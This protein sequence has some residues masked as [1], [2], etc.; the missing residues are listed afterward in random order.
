MAKTRSL[1][2]LT[3]FACLLYARPLSGTGAWFFHDFSIAY[4]PLRV[5][6]A[7]AVRAGHLPLWESRMGNGF[8]VLA[9]SQAGVFY[10]PHLLGYLGLPHYW[11]YAL[12]IAAHGILA[13]FL[14][15]ALCGLFGLRTGPCVLAGL[16]YGFSGYYVT[17]AMHIPYVEAPA[18]TPGVLYAFERWLREPRRVSWLGWAALALGVQLVVCSAQF[19]LYSVLALLLYA[20]IALIVRR[21]DGAS[22]PCR[23]A[24]GWVVL[25]VAAVIPVA[26]AL[27]A[28]QV[29][30]TRALIA[31]SPRE[32]PTPST[33]RELSMSPHDLAFFLHPYIFGSYAGGDYFGGDHHYEVCGYVGTLALL[34]GIIGA[35]F[36]RGR[37]RAFALTLVPLALFMALAHQN[38]LYELL[39][40]VPGLK[41][42]RG[43]GRYTVLST[44]GLAVLAAYGLQWVCDSRRA[45]RMAAWLGALGLAIMLSLPLLLTA[46]APMIAPR[47]ASRVHTEAGAPSAAAE[48][49]GKVGYI[50]ARLSASDPNGLMI[51]LCLA[52]I[53]AACIAALRL[54]GPAQVGQGPARWIAGVVVVLTAAQLYT[55][56]VGYNPC[57]DPSYFTQKPKLAAYLNTARGDCVFVDNQGELQEAIPGER[58]WATGDL[59][60]YFAEKQIL[61]PNRQVLYDL[62][63]ANV[64]YSLVPQR[65]WVLTKLLDASLRER[66]DKDTGLQMARPEE[67]VGA[68]GA[69]VICTARREAFAD[70]PVAL[71]EGTWLARLNPEA[72]PLAYFADAAIPCGDEGSALA[73][74]CST[75]YTWRRPPV[76]AHAG[77]LPEASAG[78]NAQVMGVEN[79]HGHLMIRCRA[80]RPRLLVVR[81]TFSTQFRCL[82]D[83][84]AT[85]FWRANYLYR[86]V[87]VPAGE[88]Q[89]EFVYSVQGVR[90]GAMVSVIT[91]L[92]LPLVLWGLQRG[93]QPLTGPA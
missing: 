2:A 40:H 1:I 67:V 3:A 58:G 68:M 6:A 39:P 5:S 48:A 74:M 89:V 59:S 21:P 42:F 33:L 92:I 72:A 11:V 84:V 93:L 7:E 65:Y 54:S 24:A 91:L 4:P 86:A 82:V 66:V 73:A 56:G 51:L 46:A 18:W 32:A 36:A 49:A 31:E 90:R 50:A 37:A 23:P 22:G 44:L 81:E 13:A 57:I 35:M 87:V 25:A 55:F 8:P 88:H 16:I 15:A 79:D 80:E 34:L 69:R 64:F 41:Y 45:Q 43:A 27:S 26:V 29:L 77:D 53:T 78:G 9:E 71:D 28:V 30:P 12:L 75:D 20:F 17:H 70:M 62:R 63:S 19:F 38:P 60:Y 47:L 61:R 10:P 85:P 52:G 14:M 83:G 76:E